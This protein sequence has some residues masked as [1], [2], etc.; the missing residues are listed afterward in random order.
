LLQKQE[1]ILNFNY[2]Q[3]IQ[4]KILFR[5]QIIK[6]NKITSNIEAVINTYNSNGMKVNTPDE[7]LYGEIQQ[8]RTLVEDNINISMVK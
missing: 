5:T 2:Y 7:G 6:K 8:M 4:S 3:S 1:I